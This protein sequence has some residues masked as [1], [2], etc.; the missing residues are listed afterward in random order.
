MDS[1]RALRRRVVAAFYGGKLAREHGL[2]LSVTRQPALFFWG[3]RW[4]GSGRASVY[5]AAF[6]AG[7]AG[8]AADL[9]I[10]T[11]TAFYPA[12]RLRHGY[13]SAWV[14]HFPIV[15]ILAETA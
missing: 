2:T 14:D 3:W 1:A 9:L 6:L 11:G 13:G 15:C 12:A 10:Y 8:N 7:V 5:L 4:L